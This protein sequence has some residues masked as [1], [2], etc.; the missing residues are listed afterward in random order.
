MYKIY[1][2]DF[3]IARAYKSANDAET[4]SRVSFTRTYA[5]PEVIAQDTRGLRADIFSLGCVFLEMMVTLISTPSRD[6][7]QKLV[8]VRTSSSE[9]S[10]YQANLESMTAWF[11]ETLPDGGNRDR[12][13][14]VPEGL[15]DLVYIML[16]RRPSWR[17]AAAHLHW[18]LRYLCCSVCDQGPE[19]FEAATG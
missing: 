12:L 18:K 16:E 13:A 1:I 15:P 14:S 11:F 2:A 7:R 10:S 4:D 17:P 8:E 5:A 9:D 6:E 3:G 19:P